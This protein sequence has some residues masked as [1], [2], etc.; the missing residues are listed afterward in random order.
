MFGLMG[1]SWAPFKGVSVL[2]TSVSKQDVASEPPS[3]QDKQETKQDLEV[4]SICY[5]MLFICHG[6]FPARL[7][8]T[9]E[10]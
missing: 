10:F 6:A 2:E 3:P 1:E 5:S 9:F 4:A 7:V 8:Q